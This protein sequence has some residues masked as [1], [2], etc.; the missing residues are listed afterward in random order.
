[1][2]ALTTKLFKMTVTLQT[3]GIAMRNSA[4]NKSLKS[5]GALLL[6]FSNSYFANLKPYAC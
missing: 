1:M 6:G 4:K 5:P 2:T 3:V